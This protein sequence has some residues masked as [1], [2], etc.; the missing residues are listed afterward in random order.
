MF[1]KK[2]KDKHFNL[3]KRI[4]IIIFFSNTKA[5]VPLSEGLL[6]LHVIAIPQFY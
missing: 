3:E 4:I 5:H 1:E 2:K 6:Q